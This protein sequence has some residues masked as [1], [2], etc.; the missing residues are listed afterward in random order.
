MTE[1]SFNSLGKLSAW[2]KPA[3]GRGLEPQN[4][5][6]TL[7]AEM[8]HLSLTL[9]INDAIISISERLPLAASG[10]SPTASRRDRGYE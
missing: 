8:S 3:P 10:C 5:K 4:P 9:P 2:Q 6:C 1:V 7:M